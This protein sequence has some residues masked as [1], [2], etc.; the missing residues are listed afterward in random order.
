MYR[1]IHQNI[2]EME[3]QNMR[4]AFSSEVPPFTNFQSGNK[5]DSASRINKDTVL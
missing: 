2:S 5:M 4:D 3:P 1:I